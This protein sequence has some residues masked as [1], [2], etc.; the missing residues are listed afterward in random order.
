MIF[1]L[2]GRSDDRHFFS[3]IKN[4]EGFLILPYGFY[5]KISK[6]LAVRVGLEKNHPL[7]EDEKE[8]ITVDEFEAD[9]EVVKI[10]SN[11]S[12]TME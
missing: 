7:D 3:E 6:N 10:Y 4:G 5:L 1:N 12:V 8:I 11:V 9:D 2:S